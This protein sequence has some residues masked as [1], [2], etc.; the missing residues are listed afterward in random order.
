MSK[1]NHIVGQL[2]K[3]GLLPNLIKDRLD[4]IKVVEQAHEVGIRCIEV[5]CRRPDTIEILKKLKAEFT[6]MY[7][8]VSSLVEDGPYFNFLQQRG[9]KFP[10]I[11]EAVDAGADFLVS[12]L[13]FSK[14]TYEKY[15]DHPIV[16]AISN[17]NEAIE[18]LNF[19]ANI[20]KFCN[21]GFFGGANFIRGCFNGGPIHFGIPLLLTGGI[22]PENTAEYVA[23]GMLCNVSGFDLILKGHYEAMQEK[24]DYQFIKESMQ[25]YLDVYQESRTKQY[26]NA[27]FNSGE[28]LKIQEQTGKFMNLS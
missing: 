22:R 2:L 27:D 25:A 13:S 28:G 1:K 21:P 6:D 7:F 8:G 18:Q 26:P 23:A 19:G 11:Q 14:S 3:A 10:S 24:P 4:P 9:P 12:V 5:S 17:P 15:P 20:I 16:P